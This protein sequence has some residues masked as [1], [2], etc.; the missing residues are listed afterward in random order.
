[1]IFRLWHNKQYPQTAGLRGVA[2]SSLRKKLHRD[3]Q[4]IRRTCRVVLPRIRRGLISARTWENSTSKT[5]VFSS[6]GAYLKLDRLKR[7]SSKPWL[8]HF[9]NSFVFFC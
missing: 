1:M 6:R 9:G 8:M 3:I 2:T 5:V 7:S 4:Y